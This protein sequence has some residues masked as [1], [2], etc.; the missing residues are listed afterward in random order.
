MGLVH[1]FIFKLFL[2]ILIASPPITLAWDDE[3]VENGYLDQ[4]PPEY[5]QQQQLA[6]SSE[7]VMRLRGLKGESSD[8]DV[9]S[10]DWYKSQV[11]VPSSYASLFYGGRRMH[12]NSV[13]WANERREAAQA[14]K[15]KRYS[16]FWTVV[17]LILN[18]R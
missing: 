12:P 7:V 1:F 15:K 3:Q 8:N 9:P 18:C 4:G 13:D 5:S 17:I 2:G 10:L 6:P 16:K 14:N 11:L